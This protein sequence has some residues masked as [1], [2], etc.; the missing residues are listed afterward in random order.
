[1]STPRALARRFDRGAIWGI[2]WG[3]RQTHSRQRQGPPICV[4][5]SRKPLL[6]QHVAPVSKVYPKISSRSLATAVSHNDTKSSPP[7]A[8]AVEEGRRSPSSFPTVVR[9]ARENMDKY[10]DCVLLTR[11]GGFYELYFE[12]AEEYGRLLGL[13]VSSKKTSAGPVAMSGFPYFQIDRYLKLLVDD[14][15]KHVA[16]SEEFE[17]SPLDKLKSGG[18]LFDRRIMR[19]ITPGTLIDEQFLSPTENNY[20]LA[21][22]TESTSPNS[23]ENSKRDDQNVVGLAWLD[24]S[25]GDFFTQSIK[26]EHLASVVARINPREVVMTKSGIDP[27][28]TFASNI[29]ND[30]QYKVTWFASSKDPSSTCSQDYPP[31]GEVESL[32]P[33]ERAAAALLLS[34]ARAQLPGFQLHLQP[35]KQHQTTE[36]MRIDRNT[37]RGLEIV[38]TLREGHVKGSL[39]HA[40]RRTCTQSGTRL[41]SQRLK[42]PSMSLAEIN[43][44]LDLVQEL[45]RDEAFRDKLQSLLRKTS[46]SQRLVQKFSYGKGRADD[47]LALART[48]KVTR[49][50]WDLI[51]QPSRECQTALSPIIGHLEMEEPLRLADEV[52]R[53]IDEDGLTAQ[54]LKAESAEAAAVSKAR[55]MI[56]G[57]SS[58]DQESPSNPDEISTPSRKRS[59]IESNGASEEK[60]RPEDI[61]IMR[62]DASESLTELHSS[63]ETSYQEKQDLAEYIGRKLG[64]QSLTLRY[65]PGIGHF[66]HVKGKDTKVDLSI[67]KTQQNS[68]VYTVSQSKSTSGFIFNDWTELG[69]S[70]DDTRSRIRSEEQAILQSL[71]NRVNQYSGP[72]RQNAATLDRLDVSASFASLA[73]EHRLVRP[74][75]DKST[76][77]NVRGGRHLTVEAGLNVVGRS[78]TPNDCMLGEDENSNIAT[79]TYSA[80]AASSKERIWL[81]TGPNMAGKSTFLRQTALI[82]ILAQTGSFVPASHARLGLVDAVFSRVGSADNLASDQSTFMVEMIETAEILRDA[83]ERSLV[84]MD[85]VGRGT[86]VED[87]IAVGYAVLKWLASIGDGKGAR[88]LFATHFHALADL[89]LGKESEITGETQATGDKLDFQGKL[90]CY[91]TRVVEENDA[92]GKGA[93]FRFDHRMRPGVNRDSHALKVARLAGMPS[94][95]IETAREVLQALRPRL[96]AQ[97][98]EALKKD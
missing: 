36:Y 24:I 70:I 47:L 60:T 58:N 10:K 15:S 13:K 41:L 94:G 48:I 14:F 1:M 31:F 66:C 34:Y 84:V 61:W 3:G 42:S 74:Q 19:I 30:Q 29:T 5:S 79:E 21:V 6:P 73:A 53:A 28:E 38:K 91:C 96:N 4:Q 83:T 92:A 69:L 16:I 71:R 78:F 7:I 98:L 52:S 37:L 67:L 76:A 57:E 65:S 88:A 12:Q 81:I 55:E 75:L 68:K 93:S 39:L 56:P 27:T 62:R 20:L 90:A 25:S 64:A 80:R 89:T 40:V 35:P 2:R 86:T 8:D 23:G 85:E 87:G 82:A 45:S 18:L 51:A 17:K 59:K 95:A 22:E 9:Q 72:L 43:Q 44:R 77:Y 26:S 97:N 11:V 33:G 32:T 49:E 50:I 46:D 54:Q 63:L